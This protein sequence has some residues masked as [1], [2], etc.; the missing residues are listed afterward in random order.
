MRWVRSQKEGSRPLGHL[1]TTPRVLTASST[2]SS[3][4]KGQ[5]AGS[6]SGGQPSPELL[7]QLLSARQV[8]A[9]A[10]SDSGLRRGP[11][12]P[13]VGRQFLGSRTTSAQSPEVVVVTPVH[14]ED[15]LEAYTTARPVQ[16]S[17][18]PAT[19]TSSSATM[20]TSGLQNISTTPIIRRRRLCDPREVGTQRA[21]RHF[22]S[23][24]FAC[25][26]TALSSV[27]SSI[28]SP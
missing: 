5:R 16:S 27:T 14:Q 17:I 25:R 21:A 13:A 2:G 28:I 12:A 7:M 3:V 11:P 6:R 1:L 19:F 23:K 24:R 26:N 10:G 18:I 8:G 15:I 4:L 20:P 9:R 22:G